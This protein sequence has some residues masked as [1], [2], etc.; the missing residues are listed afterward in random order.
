M[1]T[2]LL[3]AALLLGA[4]SAAAGE[5]DGA[6]LNWEASY[7]RYLLCLRPPEFNPAGK[8][9]K[10]RDLRFLNYQRGWHIG[11]TQAQVRSGDVPGNWMQPDFDDSAWARK[12]G[13]PAEGGSWY[14][15]A[16]R[17]A[18]LRGRFEVTDPARVTRLDFE[19]Q[20]L[21]GVVVYLNGKEVKRQH[22][23]AGALTGE[24]LAESYPPEAYEWGIP[25]NK[26]GYPAELS[27]WQAPSEKADRFRKLTVA[28]DPKLLVKGAN[29]LGFAV[30]RAGYNAPAAKWSYEAMN[31]YKNTPWPH[32]AVLSLKLKASPPEAIARPDR[33]QGVQLWAQDIHCRVVNRDWCEP[34]AAAPV[35]RMIGAKNGTHSGQVV[36]GSFAALKA[37]SARVSDLEQVGGAGKIPAGAVQ[38]RYALGTPLDGLREASNVQ[39]YNPVAN[40]LLEAYGFGAGFRFKNM[41]ERNSPSKEVQ[42]EAKAIALFDQLAEK[43][44]AGVPAGSCQPVWVTVKVPKDAPAGLY[45]GTLAVGAGEERKVEVRLQIIDWALPDGRDLGTFVGLQNSLWGACAQYK[46]APWS[47]EHW[48]HLERS[49]AMLAEVG[50]DLVVL[51][52]VVGGE[53][54]NGESLVP[55]LKKG[56]GY[57]YDWRTLDRYLELVARHWGKKVAVVAEI[58]QVPFRCWPGGKSEFRMLQEGVTVVDGGQKKK[59]ALGAPGG[60]DWKK[61]FPPFAKAV[62]EH[63]RAKGFESLYWGWFYD[64]VPEDFMAMAAGLN[65]AVPEV[66]WARASHNGFNQRPFPKDSRAPGLDMHI[67]GFPEPFNRAGEP[68]SQQGWK[69]SGNVLFPRVASQ[70]QAIGRIESPMALHWLPENCLVNGAAGFGRLG[71]DF[72]PPFA[73]GNWYHPFSNY[74]LCPGPEGAEGSVRFEALREGLQEAEARIQLEKA[75]KDAA[76]PAKTVLAERIRTIGALPTGSDNQPMC[77]YYG[78]WQERSWDLYAAAA[79]ALGGKAPGAEEKSRFFGTGQ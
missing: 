21:G 15:P 39:L 4:G 29:V 35:I 68:V 45:R 23:P 30:H 5:A 57:E 47:E 10:G 36:I 22:L 3:S 32:F 61:L 26:H 6:V 71:A 12:K 20:Y 60:D 53:A 1:R 62:Q 25:V 49:V 54:D 17:V 7:W 34:G 8:D 79:A 58:C 24:A 31:G 59:L 42:A 50:N 9:G 44:P 75:G 67:R 56:E 28:L 16:V 64:G 48:K 73:F 66:G 41:E 43:P 2:L 77:E 38:V 40:R 46:C 63:V 14:D 74:M 52:L 18:C 70:I 27:E 72:W 55:W 33:P 69:S 78:G 65:E 19:V 37:L 76:E 51:P 13:G 11:F